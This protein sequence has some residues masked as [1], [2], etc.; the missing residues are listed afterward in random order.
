[1][2]L[3]ESFLKLPNIKLTLQICEL[4]VFKNSVDDSLGCTQIL[5]CV[6]DTF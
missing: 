1:M 4:S 5:I 6:P 2:W 3:L